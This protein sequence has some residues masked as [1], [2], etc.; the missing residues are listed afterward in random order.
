MSYCEHFRQSGF[1]GRDGAIAAYGAADPATRD[2]LDTLTET[3]STLIE[4]AR[5]EIDAAPN[6]RAGAGVAERAAAWLKL[7]AAQAGA[8]INGRPTPAA[9]GDAQSVVDR[10]IGRGR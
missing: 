5:N 10:M 3:M 6:A 4:H 1:A 8:I 7:L 9:D 2:M